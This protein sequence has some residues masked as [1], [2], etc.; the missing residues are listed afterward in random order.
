MNRLKT[1]KNIVGK[2]AYADGHYGFVKRY[3][4]G[5]YVLDIGTDGYIYAKY[6]TIIDKLNFL[7]ITNN[8][9]VAI[10]VVDGRTYAGCAVCNP[11][12]EEEEHYAKRFALARA[13]NHERDEE[14]IFDEMS[15]WQL[16]N[17]GDE[18]SDGT[19]KT[20]EKYTIVEV[21]DFR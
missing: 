7:F 16:D 11:R 5:E 21:E 6:I 2:I 20:E 12:D 8:I 10:A 9:I 19:T 14:N 1:F 13:F 17:Y 15:E 18:D 4:D 3:E